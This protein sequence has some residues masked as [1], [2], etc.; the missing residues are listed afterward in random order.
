MK[1][2]MSNKDYDEADG[3][4]D[5]DVEDDEERLDTGVEDVPARPPKRKAGLARETKVGLSVIAVLLVVFI[6]VLIY[7][8]SSPQ[9]DAIAKRSSE[10]TAPGKTNTTKKTDSRN[11]QPTVVSPTRGGR[12]PTNPWGADFSNSGQSGSVSGKSSAT[13]STD[14]LSNPANTTR[15]GAGAS[16]PFAARESPKSSRDDQSSANNAQSKALGSAYGNPRDVDQIVEPTDRAFTGP[17]VNL[18]SQR[19]EMGS[20]DEGPQIGGGAQAKDP[21]GLNARSTQP[22]AAVPANDA[23]SQ[24]VTDTDATETNA[25]TFGSNDLLSGSSARWDENQERTTSTVPERSRNAIDEQS[26]TK[27]T[28]SNKKP[29]KSSITLA[30]DEGSST[31]LPSERTNDSLRFGF[32]GT[33]AVSPANDNRP[34]ETEAPRFAG[35]RKNAFERQSTSPQTSAGDADELESATSPLD[36]STS[37]GSEETYSIRPGDT[38]WKI[39]QRFYGSGA[40]FKALYEHNRRSLRDP[41]RVQAGVS[42]NIPDEATLRRLY[43]ELCPAGTRK[44]TAAAGRAT[45]AV[46]TT[47]NTSATYVVE[48]G[49][50]LYEIARRQLGKSSRWGEIFE[51]NR[52]VLGDKLDALSPGTELVLPGDAR[53]GSTTRQT[54]GFDTTRSDQ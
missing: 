2:T 34:K 52:D 21:F 33:K 26:F 17:S 14:S 32:G 36:R 43:P 9:D 28:K 27:N 31:T 47:R 15:N 49:D 45:R 4:F 18:S 7:R 24:D 23:E 8:L 16:D 54:G 25:R 30:G 39:S 6:A 35:S 10:P 13:T 53:R 38:Y 37:S 19:E 50:T 20:I 29:S 5:I 22:T 3:V 12:A 42:L 48:E 46:A 44:P 40:Y 1:L 11:D 41:D 51:L